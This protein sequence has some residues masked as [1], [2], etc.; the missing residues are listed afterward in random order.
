MSESAPAP[1]DRDTITRDLNAVDELRP[2]QTSREDVTYLD[3]MRLDLLAER[4]RVQGS[5]GDRAVG[6][7]VELPDGSVTTR[8]RF[9]ESIENGEER[10]GAYDG[11]GR[12]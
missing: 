8:D 10:S 2:E 11:P 12:S 3:L 6:T 4:E 5:L 7:L 9:N 1:R